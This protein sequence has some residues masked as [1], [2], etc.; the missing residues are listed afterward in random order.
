[1]ISPSQATSGL[2]VATVTE[3]FD[4]VVFA[5]HEHFTATD[6]VYTADLHQPMLLTMTRVIVE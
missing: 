2:F 1:M 3:N 4:P 5:R 6:A